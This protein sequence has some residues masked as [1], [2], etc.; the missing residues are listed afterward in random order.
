MIGEDLNIYAWRKK[1]VQCCCVLYA[2]LGEALLVRPVTDAGATTAEVYLPGPEPWYDLYTLAA[3]E[4]AL[5]STAAPLD[6][7]PVY[8]RAGELLIYFFI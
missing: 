5:V 3:Q 7:I 2:R 8:I 1:L 6:K 4:P